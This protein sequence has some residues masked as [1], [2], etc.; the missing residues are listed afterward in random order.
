MFKA[1]GFSSPLRTGNSNIVRELSYQ[2]HANMIF[3]TSNH[4]VANENNM[5]C[6]NQM[7]QL[8]KNLENVSEST[9]G[10]RG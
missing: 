2:I 4:I 1:I 9:K 6:C 7:K 8:I 3:E 5:K 10:Q